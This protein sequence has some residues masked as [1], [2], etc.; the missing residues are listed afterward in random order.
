MGFNIGNIA[1][2]VGGF[3]GNVGKEV[4]KNVGNQVVDK[5]TST[6]AK[7]VDKFEP[8]L[9]RASQAIDGV[10]NLVRPRGPNPDKV[11][12][13]KLV[14]GDGQTHPAG[15]PFGELTGTRPSN[16]STP[17]EKVLYVNGINT[18][19]ATQQ[20]TMQAIADKTGMEVV[21]LHNSTEGF[22]GDLKQS[23]GDKVDKGANAAVDSMATTIY[24]E[25]AAGRG[26]HLMAH[27]QG[28]LVTSRA[29]TDVRNRLMIEDGM[30]SAEADQALSK[31]QVESFG[32]AAASW[33]DG[34]QYVHYVNRGDPVPT[35]LGLGSSADR[36]GEP[37]RGAQVRYF[38]EFTPNIVKAHSIDTTYLD[39][40]VPFDEARAGN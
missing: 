2:S 30:T 31:V 8:V 3:L 34:P 4:A 23:A 6:V 32:S 39:N 21:G 24:D 15:T 13:G 18:D 22:I 35:M 33:P 12:D 26:I 40:R 16:G 14:G 38:N 36:G 20:A 29:L 11:N 37:G 1:R 25:L 9:Y 5:V 10:L 19:L 28:G 17:T 7:A 27:S